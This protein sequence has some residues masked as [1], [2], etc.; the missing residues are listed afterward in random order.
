MMFAIIASSYEISARRKQ[1]KAGIHDY[2]GNKLED[3]E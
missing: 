2:Y 3:H 1:W